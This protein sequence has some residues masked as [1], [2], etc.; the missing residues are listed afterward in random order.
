ML[1]EIGLNIAGDPSIPYGGNRDMC[2]TVGSGGQADFR[3]SLKLA[4]GS[5]IMAHDVVKGAIDMAFVNPS[6]L[7]TQAYR[8]VGLFDAP[9]PVRI[10][11]NYPSWDQFVIV[12]H[13]RTGL[14][15]VQDIADAKYPLKISI[16]EDPTHST[17]VLI[18]Q[19]YGF[20]LDDIVSWG[21]ELKLTGGPGNEE[22]RLQPLRDNSLDAVAD[23]GLVVWFDEALANGYVPLTYSDDCFEQVCALG[24]RRFDLHP[25]DFYQNLGHDHACFSFSGWPIYTRETMPEQAVYDVCEAI[26]SREAEIPWEERAWSGIAQP[27]TETDSTPMDVPL[28]PG[29][30]RWLAENAGR[31]G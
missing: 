30:E 13:E 31:L 8:G 19:I 5:A 9:L 4:S 11:A 25:G 3:P 21:G 17:L 1:W 14:R 27:F 18:D 12:A 6:G 15:T 16:R 22:R 26:V 20:S 28:H 23:E 7:L 10:V 24:W 2:I 29:T